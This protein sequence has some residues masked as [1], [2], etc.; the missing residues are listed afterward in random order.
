M[1][2]SRGHAQE[3]SKGTSL[4]RQLRRRRRWRSQSQPKKQTFPEAIGRTQ[5]EGHS[6][7]TAARVVHA[8]TPLRHGAHS[9]RESCH[10]RLT[11]LSATREQKLVIILFFF[12]LKRLWSLYMYLIQG[13]LPER[14]CVP[15]D[16]CCFFMQKKML[17][18]LNVYSAT[19]VLVA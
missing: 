1:H 6:T 5:L 3:M 8:R 11:L 18:K 12:F 14:K 13:R 4:L 15:L 16:R 10:P 9:S 19:R 2:T 7:S 17:F